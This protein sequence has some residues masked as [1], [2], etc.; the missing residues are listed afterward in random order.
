MPDFGYFSKVHV[1]DSFLLPV[2]DAHRIMAAYFALV[3]E[4]RYENILGTTPRLGMLGFPKE[5]PLRERE[6]PLPHSNERLKS[7][8]KLAG[9]EEQMKY[10]ISNNA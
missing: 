7:G 4:Y 5:L 6:K 10:N 3:C 2:F 1:L 8:F 9:R